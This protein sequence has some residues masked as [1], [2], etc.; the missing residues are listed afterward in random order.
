MSNLHHPILSARPELVQRVARILRDQLAGRPH[1]LDA[2]LAGKL[3]SAGAAEERVPRSLHDATRQRDRLQD[4]AEQGGRTGGQRAAVLNAGLQHRIAGEVEHCAVAGIEVLVQLHAA[5]G[6]L[7]GVDG[8]AIGQQQLRVAEA[9]GQTAAGQLAVV[10]R[11]GNV[12]GAAVHDDQRCNRG[13]GCV[14]LGLLLHGDGDTECY[15]QA[16]GIKALNSSL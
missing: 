4:V 16:K 9:S 1:D 2:V 15:C 11:I 3:D 8:A 13:G 7:D 14:S 10:A 6:R 12:A 5:D